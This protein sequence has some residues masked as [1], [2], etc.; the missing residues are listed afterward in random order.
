M[1][2]TMIKRTLYFGTPAYL[3][4][5]DE[6]LVFENAETRETKSLPI[7][8]IGV[9]ILDHQQITITQALIAKLL[10]NN[11]ALITC[12]NSHHPTGLLLNLDG[13]TL[14]SAK[15]QAQFDATV[16]AD[17]LGDVRREVVGDRELGVPRQD[18][19]H[20]GR[21]EARRSS[22][23]QRQVADAISVN[24][25]RAFLQF[26]ER[27]NRIAGLGVFGIVHLDQDGA[28]GLDDERVRRV[29]VHAGGWHQVGRSHGL[30][31]WRHAHR[32]QFK[33]TSGPNQLSMLA[34]IGRPHQGEVVALG[35]RERDSADV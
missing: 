12:D 21:G 24:V 17:G 10:S 31:L 22:V 33:A 20:L 34:E 28:V 11:V 5:K 6:Q 15:F 27:R 4:T 8:D 35:S 19:D 14:Q 3:K 9:L 32:S 16:P 1:Q 18:F 30:R 26:G 29:K 13:N 23:P 7:E 2:K 25:F